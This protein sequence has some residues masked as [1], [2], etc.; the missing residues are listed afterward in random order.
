M[1]NATQSTA[2]DTATGRLHC[3]RS[4]VRMLQRN[5]SIL[6]QNCIFSC[7]LLFRSHLGLPKQYQ[8]CLVFAEL[9]VNLRVSELGEFSVDESTSSKPD[10]A[11]AASLRA[12]M[13][14]PSLEVQPQ[15]L[16]SSLSAVSSCPMPAFPSTP[17]P[18]RP[19]RLMQQ[20]FGG[21]GGGIDPTQ[22]S[23]LLA[24][25]QNSSQTAAPSNIS[26]L[27]AP[28]PRMIQGE[29]AGPAPTEEGAAPPMPDNLFSDPEDDEGSD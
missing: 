19:S 27:L 6:R 5:R 22:V 17:N 20:L 23:Q 12:I 9:N 14:A 4:F 3:N 26:Q 18:P 10:A 28:S 29:H 15:N 21:G 25:L 8:P 24:I 16:S 11:A 7:P 13:P 1:H 2:G